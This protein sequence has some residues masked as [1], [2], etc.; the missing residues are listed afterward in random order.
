MKV[1]RQFLLLAGNRATGLDSVEEKF[2]IIA[3]TIKKWTEADRVFPNAFRRNVGPYSMLF[4]KAANCMGIVS[5][6]SW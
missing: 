6:V 2:N 1:S 4:Y 5:V 3:L